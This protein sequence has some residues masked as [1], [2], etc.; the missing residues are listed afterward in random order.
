MPPV[1]GEAVDWIFDK[2]DQKLRELLEKYSAV[3]TAKT[4]VTD[5]YKETDTPVLKWS[6]FRFSRF[7]A[8]NNEL[9]VDLVGQL[10]LSPNHDALQ[11]RPLRLYWSNARAES[12]DNNY[13]IAASMRVNAIW[14]DGNRGRSENVFNHVFLKTKRKLVNTD[15]TSP[16]SNVEYFLE[17]DWKNYPLLPLPP[18]STCP[19]CRSLG[20]GNVE[21]VMNM[22]ESGNAPRTAKTCC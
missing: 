10:R 2:I 13:G 19:K 9:V 3:Y 17:E 7:E 12:T 22:A 18:W 20:T 21:I 5:F 1:A 16:S 6:C 14:L 8:K 15:S 11:I 4:T